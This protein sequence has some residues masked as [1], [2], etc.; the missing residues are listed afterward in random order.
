V[1]SPTDALR[2]ALLC[3]AL[4]AASPAAHALTDAEVRQAA[5]EVAKDPNLGGTR[6]DKVLR[7][8]PS[9]DKP[10][11]P[12]DKPSALRWLKDL[13]GWIS[14]A[15]R[16]IVWLCGAVLIALLAVGLR[17]WIAVR[18]EALPEPEAAIPTHVQG[19][20]IRTASL[21]DV[22]GAA[23]ARLWQDGQHRAALSLLYR[24][25]LSRL[26]HRHAVAVRASSTEEECLRLAR[27]RV[28]AERGAFFARLVGVW[29]LAVYGGRLPSTDAVIALCGAFDGLWPAEAEA[30]A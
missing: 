14:E 24:G 22:I 11:Q 20:D 4:A 17:R 29:Q 8:R 19:L 5:A 18:G 9:D 12:Q 25:A 16:L 21:P 23:A 7:L 3:A 28:D 13:V 2:I 26:V 27:E 1:R 10:K 6:K 15:G 30:A